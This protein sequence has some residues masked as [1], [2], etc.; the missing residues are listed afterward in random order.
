MLA[1]ENILAGLI[2]RLVCLVE[3]TRFTHGSAIDEQGSE[4]IEIGA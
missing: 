1:L 4:G 2:L 3:A